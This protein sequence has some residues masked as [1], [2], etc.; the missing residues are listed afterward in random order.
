VTRPVLIA[1]VPRSGTSWAL[2]VLGRTQDAV[3][4]Y[5]PDNE[6]QHVQALRAKRGLG[7]F[8]VLAPGDDAPAFDALWERVFTGGW[9]SPSM[10]RTWADSM[11]DSG[12]DGSRRDVV[13]DGPTSWRIRAAMALDALP[14]RARVVPGRTPVAKSVHSAFSIEWIA[15]RWDPRVVLVTRDPRNVIASWLEMNIGDRDRGLDRNVRVRA[16]VL[17][18]LGLPLAPSDDEPVHRAAWHYGVLSAAMDRAAA[19]H[20]EWVSVSHEA[21]CEDPHGRFHAAADAAGLTWIDSCD[22][23]LDRSDAQGTGYDVKRVAA[24]QPDRWRERLTPA[25]VEAIGDELQRFPGLS[26]GEP[27]PSA[28]RRP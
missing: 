3:R 27:W 7:R 10:T 15:A 9:A 11:F 6:T 20:P 8:P 25:Q 18:P 17:E 16:R 19:R 26:S 24:A 1:G 28:E 4:Y 5:E 2:K 23:Y 12:P 13:D 21:L 22:D 14:Q